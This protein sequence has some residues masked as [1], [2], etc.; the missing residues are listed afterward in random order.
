MT[1]P[2]DARLPFAVML[3]PQA[4]RGLAGREWPRLERELRARGLP[5]R[6]IQADSGPEACAA[7]AQLPADWPALAVGG[8]G[9]AH[10]LLPELRRSGRALGLVPLGSGNDL[11]GL[12]GL[13]A[14][15]LGAALDRL[16]RPP[17]RLDLLEVTL[18]DVQRGVQPT[19]LLNGLGMGFDAQVAD[20]MTLAPARLLGLPLAGFPRYLWAALAGLRRLESAQLRVTL[21]GQP[22]YSGPS[23]LAAVMNGGRYG[24]GF[25]IAPGSD[26]QDGLL[27]VVLG[28]QLSRSALLP[29]MARV[30]QGRHLDHSQVR[31]ARAQYAELIWQSPMQTHLDGELAGRHEKLSVR[32]LPGALSFLSGR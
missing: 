26:P 30:L 12:L 6:L 2:L 1:D 24:G 23:C 7:L 14:G 21:D 28:T 11:A 22:F 25:Q 20:L 32:L 31:H 18:S 9:T 15:D 27:N 5:Y 16:T 29:L 17:Q 8:D 4:G 19:L 3:N 13:R 10:G